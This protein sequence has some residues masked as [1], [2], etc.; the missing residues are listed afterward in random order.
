MTEVRIGVEK[1][2]C[3]ARNAIRLNSGQDTAGEQDD[4]FHEA[5]RAIDRDSEDAEGE[6]NQPNDRV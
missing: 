1:A 6:Q 3:R 2:L 4:P 5:E